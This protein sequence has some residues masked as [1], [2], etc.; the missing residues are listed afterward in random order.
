MSRLVVF[1]Y[2]IGYVDCDMLQDTYYRSIHSS[3]VQ[4]FQIH[5]IY[6]SSRLGLDDMLVTSAIAGRGVRVMCTR[7]DLR[8]RNLKIAKCELE[9]LTSDIVVSP[10]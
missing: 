10:W 2:F 1:I 4:D 5:I 3:L 8:L 9:L 6:R 7:N